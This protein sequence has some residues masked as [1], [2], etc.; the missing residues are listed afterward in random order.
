[1]LCATI[2]PPVALDYIT[3]EMIYDIKYDGVY[4]IYMHVWIL[5]FFFLTVDFPTQNTVLSYK[6][7]NHTTNVYIEC[8][9]KYE[10]TI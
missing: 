6:H 1:M 5:S 9:F 8:I 7:I 4:D 10:L 3:C 2:L